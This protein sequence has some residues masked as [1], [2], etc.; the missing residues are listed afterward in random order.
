MDTELFAEF[1][2]FDEFLK[3]F[4]ETSEEENLM[5][6]LNKG[7]RL[8]SL[9]RDKVSR[10]NF[11]ADA[12]LDL[13][14]FEQ[15]ESYMDQSCCSKAMAY[16]RQ[17]IE[18]KLIRPAVKSCI[19]EDGIDCEA[20]RKLF[21]NLPVSFGEADFD[22]D[23]SQKLAEACIA[24]SKRELLSEMIP[25]K[26][27]GSCEKDYYGN[28]ISYYAP[29]P[30]GLVPASKNLKSY[31]WRRGGSSLRSSLVD[32]PKSFSYVYLIE[33]LKEY[34]DKQLKEEKE[35]F[36]KMIGTSGAE[37]TDNYSTLFSQVVSNI[38]KLAEKYTQYGI[39]RIKKAAYDKPFVK[40]WLEAWKISYVIVEDNEPAM[41]A[42]YSLFYIWLL[43]GKHD[44]VT[45][46]IGG[47]RGD[48]FFQLHEGNLYDKDT[49]QLFLLAT[50]DY[51]EKRAD[52][53]FEKRMNSV[54]RAKPY[55]TLKNIPEKY[56]SVMEKSK[57]NEY[58]GYIEVDP[59]IVLHE[60][61]IGYMYEENGKKGVDTIYNDFIALARTFGFK[62]RDEVS[63]R[64]RKLGNYHAAGLYWPSLKCICVDF[65]MP[66]SFAHEYLHMLDYEANEI[67]K[68]QIFREIRDLYSYEL[69][70]AARKDKN[71]AARLKGKYDLDYYLKAT[72]TFARCG[73]IYFYRCCGICNALV[74][75]FND[76]AFAY[77]DNPKLE[78]KIREFFDGCFNVS[79]SEIKAGIE[80]LAG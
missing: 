71:L 61:E 34:T 39:L 52:H 45:L 30:D 25:L 21:K 42:M 7:E 12:F 72:E 46:E 3:L 40:R 8:I 4:E 57:L 6:Y 19:K 23:G 29:F 51:R 60:G 31:R 68:M 33:R 5:S 14:D 70:T 74:K 9:M 2:E 36:E 27:K 59:D 64:F 65:R 53:E 17:R 10:T 66:G 37:G 62:K 63:L 54:G 38:I 22:L 11:S 80:S 47:W 49:V 79:S 16:I 69:R 15:I 35:V 50:E 26:I 75:H 20:L 41:S 28:S 76:D 67:S 32:I 1:K 24:A 73:E 44:E 18:S 77:P 78:E 48:L 13:F 55:E 43:Y 56:V 58:F